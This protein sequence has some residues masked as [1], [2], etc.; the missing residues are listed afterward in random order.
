LSIE[1]PNIIYLE[2][3]II[4]TDVIYGIHDFARYLRS[5]GSACRVI[6]PLELRDVMKQTYERVLKNY[7]E[8]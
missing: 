7:G 3:K 8:F 2:D 4:Y 1:A 5:F 6:E